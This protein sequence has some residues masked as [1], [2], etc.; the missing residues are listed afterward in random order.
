MFNLL[1]QNRKDEIRRTYRMRLVVV[2]L[3][4]FLAIETVSILLLLPSYII[5]RENTDSA[6]QNLATLQNRLKKTDV[7]TLTK[8][9]RKTKERLDFLKTASTTTRV[10]DILAASLGK[11][12][13]GLSVREVHAGK[14]G[15]FWN[16]ELRGIAEN[17]EML[18][19]F[20]R[21][22]R[23]SPVFSSVEVPVSSF[24]KEV[25]LNFVVELVSAQ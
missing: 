14:N 24:A 16:V 6:R 7:E 4:L 20:A 21:E 5:S 15:A 8:E 18:R 13:A 19:S 1:P 10:T 3:L 2:A 22:L 23:T 25:E 17:R 11:R 12:P 9:M